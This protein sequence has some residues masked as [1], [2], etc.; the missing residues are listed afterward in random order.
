MS[1]GAQSH[2]MKSIDILSDEVPTLKGGARRDLPAAKMGL[3][4]DIR[5]S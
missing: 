2:S 5:L 3:L 4:A 1:E